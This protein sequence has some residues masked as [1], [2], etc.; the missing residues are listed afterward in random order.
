MSKIIATY[1]M[2]EKQWDFNDITDEF[3]YLLYVS[4]RF[5]SGEPTTHFS[6][7]RFGYTVSED[8]ALLGEGS[9]PRTGG[10]YISTD[11]LELE[12]AMVSVVPSKTYT[13]NV[14]CEES[15]HRCESTHTI[16]VDIPP[17]PYPSWTWDGG[18]WLSPIPYPAVVEGNVYYWNEDLQNWDVVS[19][20]QDSS[21]YEV[22]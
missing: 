12:S 14:W 10:E 16:T 2:I 3:H 18:K 17:Q 7:L 5:Y 21:G 20:L 11:Q 6:N 15:G 22:I 13:L 1:N 4:F 8:A 19:Q 9:Y